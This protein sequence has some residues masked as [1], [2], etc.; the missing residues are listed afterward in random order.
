MQ[1]IYRTGKLKV[2]F[3]P[4]LSQILTEDRP[5]GQS[6]EAKVVLFSCGNFILFCS[7]M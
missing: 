2:Y 3:R 5:N 6:V 7:D 1:D 4:D